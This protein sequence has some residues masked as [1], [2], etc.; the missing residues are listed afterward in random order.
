MGGTAIKYLHGTS[1]QY[2]GLCQTHEVL[3]CRSWPAVVEL[4]SPEIFVTLFHRASNLLQ[5]SKKNWHFD[6]LS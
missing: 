6:T 3:A 5:T 1:V 4:V 2:V